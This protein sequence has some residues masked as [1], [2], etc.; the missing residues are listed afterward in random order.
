MVLKITLR[1]PLAELLGAAP[2]GLLSYAYDDAVKLAGHSCPTVAGA[3]R[4]TCEALARLYPG[5]TPVRGAVRVELR[6]AAHDGVV[7]V[8][9]M[10]A[11]YVTGAAGEGGFKGIAGHYARRGLLVF[12]A[13]IRAQLRFTRLDIGAAVEVDLPEAPPNE[14][15][16]RLLRDALTPGA[17]PAHRE[18]FARAWQERVQHVL[19]NSKEMEIGS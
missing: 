8:I 16:K 18:A 4:A 7:G 17:P 14:D 19:L 11:G 15:I 12:D 10:V 3:F 1:D 6:G 13:P 9:G 2:G 5:E